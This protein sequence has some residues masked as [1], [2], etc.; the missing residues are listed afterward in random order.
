MDKIYLLNL[1][2][3]INIIFNKTINVKT[4]ILKIRLF[5]QSIETNKNLFK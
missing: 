2:N 1:F 5:Q 4:F 3:Q